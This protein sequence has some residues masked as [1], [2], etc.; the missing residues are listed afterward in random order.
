MFFFQLENRK[1]IA[2]AD[3]IGIKNSLTQVKKNLSQVTA[4]A[5]VGE[6]TQK[7]ESVARK[8]AIQRL[9]SSI[10]ELSSKQKASETLNA[11]EG[12]K[13]KGVIRKVQ[14]DL[15]SLSARLEVLNGS[16]QQAARNA[17][18]A[19]NSLANSIAS[20]QAESESIGALL[21]G[22]VKLSG[23]D[24]AE[25]S[26]DDAATG[27]NNLAAGEA[28]AALTFSLAKVVA[29]IES[30]H[31]GWTANF[32]PKIS[33]TKGT[34]VDG[35]VG[36]PSYYY[37]SAPTAIGGTVTWGGTTTVTM[38][39]TSDITVGMAIRRDDDHQWFKV[40]S[41]VED[42]SVLIENPHGLTIPTGAGAS[43]V[44][45]LPVFDE[46]GNLNLTMVI[47]T[48]DGSTKTFLDG[49]KQD[50]TVD[51]STITAPIDLSGVSAL[52]LDIPI[53]A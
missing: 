11:A 12:V 29:G 47:D 28:T 20:R 18:T 48:D 27:L 25:L 38:T 9:D 49:E 39:D 14:H 45:N 32:H 41:I 31:A 19:R 2:Q 33:S 13:R 36:A 3:P 10:M 43:S 35:D 37:G 17:N 7:A 23:A 30:N 44:G 53:G 50:V 52:T 51:I 6:H 15:R 8:S 34:V 24:A 21:V 5:S 16:L 42:T 1:V 4:K 26:A 40:L 46:L 22:N